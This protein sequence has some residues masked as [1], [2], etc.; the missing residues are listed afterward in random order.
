MKK[1]NHNTNYNTN[2]SNHTDGSTKRKEVIDI[3][4]DLMTSQKEIATQLESQTVEQLMS[5]H[6]ND[7][8]NKSVLFIKWFSD[9]PSIKYKE[10]NKQYPNFYDK[11]TYSRMVR[12]CNLVYK[13][14]QLQNIPE[15]SL[16]SLIVK[17]ARMSNEIQADIMGQ[18]TGFIDATAKLTAK[19]L[20]NKI[21][22]VLKPYIEKKPIVSNEKISLDLK[23]KTEEEQIALIA[24]LL[25][26]LQA[27]MLE[28]QGN[29]KPS[30]HQSL[31][32]NQTL[33]DKI[34]ALLKQEYM[35]F[36]AKQYTVNAITTE[37]KINGFD[38]YTNNAANDNQALAWKLVKGELKASEFANVQTYDDIHTIVIKVL[39]PS[40][41][42]GKKREVA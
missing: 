42:H 25:S 32:K 24:N 35:D 6:C 38:N 21:A 7:D 3:R 12:Y 9:N 27:K 18:L 1:I 2:K 31:T 23:G 20:R 33:A 15:R 37:L 29:A 22:E 10:F 34:Q 28:L 4:S 5:V 8:A 40:K 11:S 14:T 30:N 36:K 16:R 26:T 13:Y 17:L 19:D 39:E 41:I